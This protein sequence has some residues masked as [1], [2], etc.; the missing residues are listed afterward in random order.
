VLPAGDALMGHP[1]MKRLTFLESAQW[2][3]R[4]RLITRQNELLAK[5]VSTAYR[6][7]PFYR[8]WF[9]EAGV[10]PDGIRSAADMERIPI[11]TKAALREA[12]PDQC[13][14]P[15][16]QKTWETSTSGSTGQGFHVREDNNTAAWYRASFLL[17]AEWAGWRIG[18]RHIQSGMHLHRNGVKA[19]KDWGLGCRYIMATDLRDRTLDAVLD[20]LDRQGI[21]HIWGYPGFAYCLALRAA[22]RG[23]NT[24]VTSIVT[25]GDTLYPEYRDAIERAFRAPIHDTYGCGEG[26]QVSAQCGYGQTYHVHDL[27]VI[28]DLLD[29][30]GAPVAAGEPG[31]VVIT[32]LQPGPM[33]LIRYKVGD[34][35]FRGDGQ[36]CACGRGFST[37]GSIRGRDTDIIVTP[38]GNHLLVHFFSVLFRLFPEV[39]SFQ[40]VQTATDALRVRIVPRRDL[41]PATQDAIIAKHREWGLTDMTIT[42]DVV[43]AIPLTVG[44]KRRFIINELLQAPRPAEANFVGGVESNQPR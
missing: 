36:D 17:A 30:D 13:V 42:V 3:N 2:W 10:D 7:V 35:A 14:R 8:N 44:G 23:W 22:K 25:W 27:D 18:E 43:P 1:M 26:F 21:R 38:S 11:V 33:P 32:R 24:P 39:D 34:V 37:M 16:G 20:L 12:Y 5:T 19:L 15:T 28:V 41:G 31:N 9:D 40:V 4:E 29:D 6:E